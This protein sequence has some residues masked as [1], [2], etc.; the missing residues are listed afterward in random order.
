MQRL[1][2][3]VVDERI[4]SDAFAALEESLRAEWASARL[5]I[6]QPIL[7][8]KIM[9]VAAAAVIILA[10]LVGVRLFV[11]SGGEETIIDKE[12]TQIV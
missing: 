5:R 11:G 6:L 12:R 9:N 4:L 3:I 10:V 8:S 7:R 2:D 1:S